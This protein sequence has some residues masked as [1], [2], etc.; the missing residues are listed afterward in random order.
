M[1]QQFLTGCSSETLDTK[2]IMRCDHK[3]CNLH[4]LFLRS[5]IFKKNR[6]P[7]NE[8]NTFG[9]D[10]KEMPLTDIIFYIDIYFV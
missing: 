2:V 3:K 1:I 4:E 6:F 10:R 8:T 5:S 9:H 7:D